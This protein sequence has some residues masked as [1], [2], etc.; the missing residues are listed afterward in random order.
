MRGRREVAV[1]VPLRV[2]CPRER[3]GAGDERK[4]REDAKAS[5]EELE[6]TAGAQLLRGLRL[7]RSDWSGCRHHP[8]ARTAGC[9]HHQ[10]NPH[11]PCEKHSF[12]R[13][14]EG[15]EPV[16]DGREPGAGDQR[17]RECAEENGRT[18]RAE[19][20]EVTRGGEEQNQHVAGQED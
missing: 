17:A 10:G 6:H 1:V 12:R 16:V 11:E 8:D 2:E 14:D 18:E 4:R 7:R 15:H 20:E 13:A 9:A 19:R 3:A 5:E